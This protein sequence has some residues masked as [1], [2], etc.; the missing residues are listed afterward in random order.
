MNCYLGGMFDPK[1]DSTPQEH[2]D[3]LFAKDMKN[4]EFYY[5][6]PSSTSTSGKVYGPIK[7][8]N[9]NIDQ[10]NFQITNRIGAEISIINDDQ[11][12]IKFYSQVPQEISGQ[13]EFKC[14]ALVLGWLGDE[15][16]PT[17]YFTENNYIILGTTN[18]LSKDKKF[19]IQGEYD[20]STSPNPKFNHYVWNN[21]WNKNTGTKQAMFQLRLFGIS[22]ENFC[23]TIST[24]TTIDQLTKEDLSE[25]LPY[26]D[27]YTL[28]DISKIKE[29]ALNNDNGASVNGVSQ[30]IL[31]IN[32]RPALGRTDLNLEDV[33][34]VVCFGIEDSKKVPCDFVGFHYAESSNKCKNELTVVNEGN[35]KRLFNEILFD[36]KVMNNGNILGTPK[37]ICAMGL[38]NNVKQDVTK[39]KFENE[40]HCSK[41]YLLMPDTQSPANA[42]PPN[43]ACDI[44]RCS[45]LDSVG[46]NNLHREDACNDIQGNLDL[47]SDFPYED[48]YPDYFCNSPILKCYSDSKSQ[49]FECKPC[50]EF[51]SSQRCSNYD[52]KDAC[53]E[54]PCTG[55]LTECYWQGTATN[56][57][58]KS[59]P[60]FADESVED[61]CRALTQ[62]VC[63]ECSACIWDT[64][65]N[66]CRA[67]EIYQ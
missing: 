47:H 48:Y 42:N 23:K 16:D 53:E 63:E 15:T 2:V 24:T 10:G 26:E 17:N 11:K 65:I 5:E 46:E 20:L 13:G 58:C 37:T 40:Q 14:A 54:D 29:E 25:T 55:V 39:I 35:Y 34:E 32:K 19:K 60:N 18:T 3:P 67:N 38:I 44:Q 52:R 64:S 12:K 59:C 56:G 50:S 33:C 21:V 36:N 22:Q 61:D 49:G 57:N 30:V 4:F 41:I 7:K 8:Y 66:N 51:P 1:E 62:S 45:E 27:T 6:I 31:E 9:D 43:M 28:V